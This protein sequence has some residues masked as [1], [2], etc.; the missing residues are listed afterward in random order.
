MC[1]A[2]SFIYIYIY[3]YIER[4]RERKAERKIVFM[5]STLVGYLKPNPVYKHAYRKYI[6]FL[7][8]VFR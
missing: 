1:N 2:K 4:E 6:W 7:N 8:S 5:A 3:I